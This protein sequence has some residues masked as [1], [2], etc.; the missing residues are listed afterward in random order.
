M[1][2]YLAAGVRD[3]KYGVVV[4]LPVI[5]AFLLAL[6]AV[7]SQF[8]QLPKQV[9]RSLTFVPGNWAAD[10]QQDAN[11]SNDYRRKV[12]TVFA[13][14]YFPIHPWLGRGFGFRS[15]I[16][17][18]SASNLRYNP[19]WDRDTVEVGNIHNGLLA[20]VDAVGIVGTIFFVGWNLRILGQTFRVSFRQ[21]GPPG[22]ALRFL[23]LYVS[24][25][26][27]GYWM[28]AYTV[29][30][31]LP[32]QFALAGVL[33]RLQQTMDSDSV[34]SGPADAKIVGD[35]VRQELASA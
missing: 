29:G 14:E 35:A 23:A 5:A 30:S 3:L 12:W 11:S 15:Q 33:L 16:A 25:W 27:I 17:Q 1:I 4:I 19:N 9:Q 20:T 26:V 34:R 18:Q 10:T 6:S 32:R 2:G 7:N 24:I 28:G 22:I 21:R 8:F 13:R 31:F